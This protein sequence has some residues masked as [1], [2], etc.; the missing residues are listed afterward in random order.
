MTQLVTRI[1]QDLADQIDR[2]VAEGVVESRSQAVREG[3]RQLVDEHRRARVA[4][5]IV[6]GYQRVPQSVDDGLWSDRA[7]VDMIG[8]EPW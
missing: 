7:T 2:L 6:E 5:E 3:L 4:A 8:Q 1:P